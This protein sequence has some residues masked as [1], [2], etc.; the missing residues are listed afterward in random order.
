M[1]LFDRLF[2]RKKD[3]D[4]N[5]AQGGTAANISPALERHV[6]CSG[7]FTVLPESEIHLIPFYN[8][9]LRNYVTTYRCDS[10]WLDGIDETRKRIE[11]TESSSEIAL[12]AEFFKRHAVFIHEYL[13]GD[14]PEEV[15]RTLLYLIDLMKTGGLKLNIGKTEPME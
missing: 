8:D 4:G 1:G 5:A 11:L 15:K 7:C 10:C 9:T 13:R 14:P 3:E 6:F 12:A 2:K